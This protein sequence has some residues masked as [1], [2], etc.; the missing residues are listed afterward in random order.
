MQHFSLQVNSDGARFQW[1]IWH[2][3]EPPDVR[4]A[5]LLHSRM[6]Y[7]TYKAALDGGALMLARASGQPYGHLMG[8][9]TFD[10]LDAQIDRDTARPSISGQVLP[11]V[12]PKQLVG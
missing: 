1:A 8:D 9:T 7:Q 3:S 10:A 6:I 5:P 12:I 2:K 4:F 11:F